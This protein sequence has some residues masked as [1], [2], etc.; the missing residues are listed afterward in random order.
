VSQFLSALDPGELQI[1]DVGFVDPEDGGFILLFNAC[2]DK[3]EGCND[4]Y[5]PENH[6]KAALRPGLLRNIVPLFDGCRP[7]MC[8]TRGTTQIGGRGFQCVSVELFQGV[9]LTPRSKQAGRCRV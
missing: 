1:G 8:A 2:H 9:L 5:V 6:E 3:G 4:E 7:Y